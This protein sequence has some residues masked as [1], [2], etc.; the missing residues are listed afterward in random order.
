MKLNVYILQSLCELNFLAV[1]KFHKIDS[2]V[3]Y[4]NKLCIRVE[5]YD[6]SMCVKSPTSYPFSS[7]RTCFTFFFHSWFYFTI[8]WYIHIGN[9]RMSNISSKYLIPMGKIKTG[10]GQF[11][12][13]AQYNWNCLILSSSVLYVQ[14][15]DGLKSIYFHLVW[16]FIHHST[17]KDK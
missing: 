11:S 16:L 7:W 1:E 14:D 8:P 6:I 17:V 12:V 13:L 15:L 4:N 9:G 5:V 10:N 3:Q 2:F